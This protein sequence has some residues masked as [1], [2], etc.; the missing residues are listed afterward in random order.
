M[1][2][3]TGRCFLLVNDLK[4]NTVLPVSADGTQD[5]Q[6][7]ILIQHPNDKTA[8]YAIVMRTVEDSYLVVAAGTAH[9]FVFISTCC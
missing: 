2:H 1:A 7:V 9:S 8:K 5:H 6:A 4:A 3:V